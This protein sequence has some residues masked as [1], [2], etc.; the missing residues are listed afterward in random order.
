MMRSMFSGVSG[1]RVHQTKMD[2]IANN[3]SNVNTT[4]FKSSRVTF[5]EIFAQ[6]TRGASAANDNT[7]RGGTN[8]MQIGLGT[9]VAS[10]DLSTVQG[11]AQRTDNPY[12]LMIQGEGFFIVGDDSGVKFT[13][14]GAFTLDEAGNFVNPSG[15]KVYGWDRKWNEE[16][17]DW[18]IERGQVQPITIS[19]DK[20]YAPPATTTQI[21]FT[22]NLNAVEDGADGFSMQFNFY[23]SLG[24]RFVGT[25]TFQ[26]PDDGGVDAGSTTWN[27]TISPEVYLAGDTDATY[28]VDFATTSGTVVFG[29]NG[30]VQSITPPGAD[31]N[32]FRVPV[33]ATTITPEDGSPTLP[34]STLGNDANQIVFD[35][36][37][38]TQF[39]DK[40]TNATS[41]HAD[42]HGPGA[43][44]NVSVGT[45]GII[46]G[47]YSNS[48]LAILGQIPVATFKN[49]AGLEKA[50]DSLYLPSANSGEF[51]GIG[52]EIAA[53]GGKIM[54]GVLEMSNVDLSQEF[55]EMIT[56]QRGFQANSRIITTSDEMLQ[57]LVN[58]KR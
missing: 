5:A 3:I 40:K 56:T 12:D 29:T 26:L 13:R 44:I 41:E 51:D 16:N 10:I 24:N 45:D 20:W 11:A 19:G 18:E 17:A 43:L 27:Y 15:L 48:E 32:D 22:D 25:I 46:T 35:F 52:E 55:T 39:G 50:G 7:G 4:G 37:G 36:G 31:A 38:L 21:D 28:T 23:D 6:T 9:T 49:P 53:T 54:G 42:G 14:A 1:L 8:P 58:L 47:L 30:L 2:V 33:A 34:A 57:E